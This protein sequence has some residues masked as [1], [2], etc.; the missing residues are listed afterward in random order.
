VQDASPAEEG[1]I[2]VET[3]DGQGNTNSTPADGSPLF[4]I[5][6]TAR[7]LNPIEKDGDRGWVYT[8]DRLFAHT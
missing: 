1:G 5:I 7:D 4:T 2:L 6:S 8:V 3:A